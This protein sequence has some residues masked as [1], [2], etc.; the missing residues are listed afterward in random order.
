MVPCSDGIAG[1]LL[2]FLGEAKDRNQRFV[3]YI[4]SEAVAGWVK[5]LES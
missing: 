2:A 4:L 5:S 3:V 1:E